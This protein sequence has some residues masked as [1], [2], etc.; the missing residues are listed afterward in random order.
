MSRESELLLGAIPWALPGEYANFSGEDFVWGLLEDTGLKSDVLELG[1][2]DS[3]S[4]DEIR[5]LLNL[6]LD[7]FFSTAVNFFLISSGSSFMAFAINWVTFSSDEAE[8]TSPTDDLLGDP[9][10]LECMYNS[11]SSCWR[12]SSDLED[13]SSG[14]VETIWLS[15]FSFLCNRFPSLGLDL[16]SPAIFLLGCTLWELS[17][18]TTLL[19]LPLLLLLCELV[20]LAVL[21]LLLKVES[22][23]NCSSSFIFCISKD[24]S[25]GPAAANPWDLEVPGPLPASKLSS[26]FNWSCFW[27]F[28]ATCLGCCCNASLMP[29]SADVLFERTSGGLLSCINWSNGVEGLLIILTGGCG[30]GVSIGLSSPKWG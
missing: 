16:I 14:L 23:L 12:P 9:I 3:T 26:F 17:I 20:W 7:F 18:L 30:E 21:L 22:T 15:S 2:I 28:L 25:S 1:D 27:G 4:E 8:L 24:N 10:L 29:P 5:F 6:A 11:W 19:I 13:T